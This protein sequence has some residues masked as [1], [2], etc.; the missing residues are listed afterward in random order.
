MMYICA[1]HAPAL[2]AAAVDLL[3]DDRRLG[4]AE[5]GPAVLLRNQRRE[6]AGVGQRL[7]E[8]PRIA[9]ASVEVAPVLSGNVAHRLAHRA[10]QVGMQLGR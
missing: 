5:P 9:A 2:R 7:N 1:W 3:E 8:L 4:D 10:S 6:V